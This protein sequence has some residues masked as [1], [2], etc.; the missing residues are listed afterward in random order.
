MS[1]TYIYLIV[2]FGVY[3]F[4]VKGVNLKESLTVSESENGRKS[5][6]G[7]TADGHSFSGA[8]GKF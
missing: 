6:K 5:Y 8:S 2:L 3:L 7:T 1:K 4:I